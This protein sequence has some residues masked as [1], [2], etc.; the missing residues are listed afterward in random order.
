M[1]TATAST[2]AAGV[3]QE[4][5]EARTWVHQVEAEIDSILTDRAEISLMQLGVLHQLTTGPRRMSDLASKVGLSPSG[6]TRVID[7]LVKRGW[8]NR[9]RFDGDRRGVNAVLTSHGLARHQQAWP[10][11]LEAATKAVVPS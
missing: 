11:Y 2:V 6:L 8:V 4:F 9:S 1:S 3:V 5:E 7:S 10:I